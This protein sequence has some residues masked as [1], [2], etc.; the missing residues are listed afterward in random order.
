MGSREYHTILAVFSP[1]TSLVWVQQLA[2]THQGA[3]NEHKLCVSYN[4]CTTGVLVWAYC[5][6]IR[7]KPMLMVVVS[8]G[9]TKTPVKRL[10]GF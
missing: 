4:E 10:N 1:F 6:K 8:N 3:L 9:L 5:K 2:S 7:T